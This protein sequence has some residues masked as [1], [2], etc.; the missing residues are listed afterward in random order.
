YFIAGM[1]ASFTPFRCAENGVAMV[2]SDGHFGSMIV[3]ER[4]LIV[5]ELHNE[6]G[7]KTGYISGKRVWTLYQ[8]IGDL[9]WYLCIVGVFMPLIQ[10]LVQKRKTAVEERN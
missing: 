4:G 8:V 3:N 10:K 6:Q 7:G 1:H 5:T 9:F 2:R